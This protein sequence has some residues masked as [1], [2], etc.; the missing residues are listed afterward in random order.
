MVEVGCTNAHPQSACV[1]RPISVHWVQLD[2]RLGVG[3]GSRE[4]L[5]SECP[6]Q[7]PEG[8]LRGEPLRMVGNTRAPREEEAHGMGQGLGHCARRGRGQEMFPVWGKE[9]ETA[10]SIAHSGVSVQSE[11]GRL[12]RTAGECKQGQS[13]QGTHTGSIAINFLL[14]ERLFVAKTMPSPTSHSLHTCALPV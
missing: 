12:A 4:K 9:V 13:G 14:K 2:A 1:I 5:H 3:V 11:P 6:V 7:D 8:K 10:W